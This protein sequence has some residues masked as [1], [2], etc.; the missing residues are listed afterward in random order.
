[1][2]N[3]TLFQSALASTTE[4]LMYQFKTLDLGAV[5]RQFNGS[6]LHSQILG[7]GLIYRLVE[8]LIDILASLRT[9]NTNH[10]HDVYL[11][12]LL[13]WKLHKGVS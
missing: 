11:G 12:T 5:S 8:L 7:K 10:L 3:N 2:V 4:T 1:M 9:D 13:L 6:R